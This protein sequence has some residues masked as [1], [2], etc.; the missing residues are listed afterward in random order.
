LTIDAE[1]FVRQKYYSVEHDI[2][3]TTL[4]PKDLSPETPCPCHPLND[5]P[6]FLPGEFVLV[7]ERDRLQPYRFEM[8]DDK[9]AWVRNMERRGEVEGQGKVN[10]LVWTE[11]VIDVPVK[12]VVRK[13]R[14][15]KV[16]KGEDIPRL[17]DWGGSSDW[18]FYREGV[19]VEKVPQP[20]RE[21]PTPTEVDVEEGVAKSGSQ[22]TAIDDRADSVTVTTEPDSSF[23]PASIPRTNPE[24]QTIESAASSNGD[25]HIQPIGEPA[26]TKVTEQTP[27]P[28]IKDEADRALPDLAESAQEIIPNG[29]KLRGLDLFCGGGNFGRGVGDG[30]AVQ[31]KW[32]LLQEILLTNQGCRH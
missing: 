9:R 3:V 11:V 30:G 29:R 24:D 23:P 1:F 26:D 5:L 22:L 20:D 18:F 13:C 4:T 7:K 15:V 6:T 25:N 16:K 32:C 14:V 27:T 31:H 8:Y 28:A 17:A 10:E 12:R 2:H 21:T 19:K